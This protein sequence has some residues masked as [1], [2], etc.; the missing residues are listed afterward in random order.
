MADASGA[1]PTQLPLAQRLELAAAIP[2]VHA[3]LIGLLGWSRL[4]VRTDTILAF[5]QSDALELLLANV[6]RARSATDAVYDNLAALLANCLAVDSK[7]EADPAALVLDPSR[8][9]ADTVVNAVRAVVRSLQSGDKRLGTVQDDAEDEQDAPP[10]LDKAAATYL[11]RMVVSYSM[12]LRGVD[13]GSERAH[14]EMLAIET[15]LS[16]NAQRDRAVQ[17]QGIRDN[18]ERRDIRSDALAL[19]ERRLDVVSQLVANKLA[20]SPAGEE[21]SA[22]TANSSSPDDASSTGFRRFLVSTGAV[23][24]EEERELYDGVETASCEGDSEMEQ[25]TQRLQA[26]HARKSAELAGALAKK[27]EADGA[28]QAL[29]K[30]REALEAQLRAVAAQIEDAVAH[31]E[32]VDDEVAAIERKYEL[33]SD[34]FDTQHEHVIRAYERRQRRQE[35]ATLVDQAAAAVREISLAG[36]G[37]EPLQ[38]KQTACRTQHLEAVLNY[39]TSELPCVKF[40]MA[41]AVQTQEELRKL[42]SEAEGYRALGV[43]SV[44]KELALKAE[45]LQTHLN[46]DCQTLMALRT[47]DLEIIDGVNKRLASVSKEEVDAKLATDVQRHVEYVKKLYADC[48]ALSDSSSESVKAGATSSKAS[49]A[50]KASKANANSKAAV[51]G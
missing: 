18:F 28:L 7:A 10:S 13:S 11:S 29:R 22:G 34:A 45:T 49:G 39:F 44:A 15:K 40:M 38:N 27:K 24:K 19:L 46:E 3:A 33:E 37:V 16:A 25:V 8:Q 36:S 5:F 12:S 43:S 2:D 41:R 26:L 4:Y 51:V 17:G 20:S 35:V 32:R 6:L 23:S 47:R 42:D 50:S 1:D 14:K 30:Q 31:Q 48:S 9:V 21:A